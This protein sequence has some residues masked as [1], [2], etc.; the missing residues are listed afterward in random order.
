M[1]LS[2]SPTPSN[3]PSNTPTNTS[4]GTQCPTNTPT[5]SPTN[6]PSPTSICLQGTGLTATSVAKLVTS[7]NTIY[8]AA[9][10]ASQ[11]NGTPI[12]NFFTINNN[13]SL[14]LSAATIDSSVNDILPQSDGKFLVVG[15]FTTVSGISRNRI[16]RLNA[17]GTLDTTFVVGTG[18]GTTPALSNPRNIG[19]NASGDY[20]IVGQFTTYSGVSRNNIIKLTSTGSID[21]SFVIGSGFNSLTNTVLVQNDGKVICGGFFTSYSGVS[22]NRIVKLNTNGSIDN[23]FITGTGFTNDIFQ[24]VQQPDGKI[25]CVGNFGAYNGTTADRVCRLNTDGTIDNTFTSLGFNG[26]VSDVAIDVDGNIIVIGA[27]TTYNGITHNRIVKLNPDGSVF[28]GWNSGTGTNSVATVA[29]LP[30]KKI[31]VGGNIITTYNGYFVP[32]LFM[33][34][35]Y[36]TLIDCILVPVTP[37]RTPT[38]TPTP[39]VSP[40]NTPSQTQTNTPTGTIVL[41]PS[42]TYTPTSTPTQTPSNT[43]SQ[44]QTNTPTGTIVLTPTQTPSNTTTQTPSQTQTQT[45]TGTLTNTPTNTSTPTRTPEITPSMTQTNTA[46]PTMTPSVVIET[47]AFLTIRTDT[48]LDV[49]ITGVDVNGVP[50]S[51]LSGDTFP[52]IPS[53]PPGYYNTTTT[54][55]SETV[56]ITY[57]SNIA[58]QRIVLIDCS[59]TSFCCDL[60]PGG[61][62][63]TFTGVNLSCGCNWDIQAYDGTC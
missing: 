5:T 29:T 54:G 20:F 31:I 23:T 13:G 6:T 24:M 28:A 4:S 61:G 40:S 15:E 41:T 22:A 21:N 35:E 59:F 43:P 17:N 26:V 39:E 7:G 32:Q 55:T 56:N 49:P 14:A 33:L 12:S 2:I 63:C 51:Y 27:F 45:N 58:G 9:F 1:R 60:N 25:I 46:T 16:A 42:N 52:I 11:Y 8:V 3:T 10:N 37:T 57:G 48:S 36:G 47:C 38:A 50:V 62:T 18:F 34:N 53:D 30:D 44:T 19:I